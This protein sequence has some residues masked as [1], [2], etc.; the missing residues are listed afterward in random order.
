MKRTTTNCLSILILL[1]MQAGYL[2]AQE[3]RLPSAA[4]L[5]KKSELQKKYKSGWTNR[6]EPGAQHLMITGPE[7]NCNNAIPVCQQTYTQGSSYTGHGTIQELSTTC[8]TTDETNSV[9]YTFT[10]QNSGTFTFLLN[11]ANDYDFALYD[12]TTIGCAGVPSATPIRCNFSA[13]YGS[14]GLTLPAGSNTPNGIPASGVPTMPGLN[15]TAGQTFALIIDNYSANSNGY[16]LTFGGTAQIFDNT[17]P[18]ISSINASCTVGSITMMLNEPIRCNSIEALGS[19]F[20]ITGPGGI[21]IPVTAAVGNCSGGAG[22]T[23]QLTITYNNSAMPTGTYT[24]SSATGTDGNTVLDNCGNVMNTGLTQ[25]FNHL[26][27]LSISATNTAICAGG[28][29]V[30]TVNGGGPS[31]TY[32]WAPLAGSDSVLTVTPLVTTNYA[33]TVSFGGCTANATQ[34]IAIA[35]PPVVNVNPATVSLCSGVTSVLA[36][37][38]M[39][40]SICTNCDFTWTGTVSQTDLNTSTSTLSGVGAGSYSVQV[41]SSTGCV[42][43]TAVSTVSIASPSATP[44]CDIIYVSPAGGGDGLTKA[45]PTD[46]LSAIAMSQCNNSLLKLQI[47]DYTIN[48]PLIIGSLITIEGGYNVGFT[49][50]TSGKAT[51]GGFPLQGTRIIRSS[52]NPETTM[53]GE[54]HYTGIFVTSG[55]SYFRLQDIMVSMPDNAAGTA[56]SNYGIYLGSSCNNYNITRCYIYSGN[57]GSGASS[58]QPAIAASGQNGSTGALNGAGG[59]GALQGSTGGSGATAA[60]GNGTN[61]NVGSA[62]LVGNNRSG[63]GG[64]GGGRGGQ[65]GQVGGNGGNGGAGGGGAVGGSTAGIGGDYGEC[66]IAGG[67]NGTAG[68]NGATGANGAAAGTIGSAGTDA[69]G[70]WIP[71]GQGGPGDDGFG[72]GGGEGGGAGGGYSGCFTDTRGG[73]GGGGGGGG[74]GGQGGLGGFGGGSTYGIFIFNNGVNGNIV[75][76][77]I[78]NGLAGAGGAGG[79]GGQGGPGGTGGAGEAGGDYDGAAGGAGGAGGNGAAGGVGSDGLADDVKLVGGVALATNTS[80]VLTNQALITAE[81]IACTNTNID[82]TATSANPNWIN[83]G[84]NS[85]PTT[86]AGTPFNNVQYTNSGLQTISLNSD[87][88]NSVPGTVTGAAQTVSNTASSPAL[89][90]AGACPTP[91]NNNIVVSGYPAS[92]SM[93][94]AN[95]SVRVSLGN[96]TWSNDMSLFLIAPSGQILGLTNNRANGGGCTFTNINFSDAGGAV[97]GAT[98]PAAGSTFRPETT[99]YTD[100]GTTSTIT[101]FA[102]IGGAI[103]PNGTWTLRVVD[104]VDL[105]GGGALAISGWSISLP[106]YSYT[107][108]VTATGNQTDVYTDFLNIKTSAPAPGNILASATQICPDTALYTATAIG[109]PGFSFSWSVLPSAGVTIL[110][111]SVGATGI[112][113]PNATANPITYTVTLQVA[114]ECCGALAPLTQTITVNPIPLDPT[115]ANVATC[116]GG[117]GVFSVTAP[118]GASFDWYT[119]ATGGSSINTGTTYSVSPVNASQTFYVQSISAD[120]CPS[121]RVPVTISDTIIP[122]PTAIDVIECAPG[123]VQVGATAVSG[124]TIYNWYSDA[125]GTTLLQSGPS[126]AYGVDV[127]TQGGTVTVYVSDSIPGCNESALVPVVASVSNNPILADT[128]YSTND[129]VCAGTNVTITVVPT[130]GSGVYTYTWSPNG[131]T[132]SFIDIT[133]ATNSTGYSVIIDDGACAIQVATPLIVGSIGTPPSITGLNS[134]CEGDSIMLVT[135]EVSGATYSWNGPSGAGIGTNDTLVISGSSIANSGAYTVF[136]NDGSLCPNP[137]SAYN[138]TVNALPVVTVNNIAAICSGTTVSV[139]ANNADSY[140]WSIGATPTGVNT[141][142]V[143]PTTQTTYTVTGLVTATG[144]T[145]TTAFTV[146][147]NQPPLVAASPVSVCLGSSVTVTATGADS[148]VWSTTAIT[149]TITVT[150]ATSGITTYTV[151]GTDATTTCTNSVTVD[152]TAT[153]LPVIT[154]STTTPTICLGESATLT[155]ANGTTYSWLPSGGTNSTET[156]TPGLGT[157][158]YTVTGTISGCSNT[159]T[160]D[161]TVN[162]LPS[163]TVNNATICLGNVA[164]LTASDNTNTY[165][166]QTGITSTGVTTAEVSPTAP[167]TTYTVTGMSTATTC[168]ATVT[169]TVDVNPLPT[170]A[171]TNQLVCL[172]SPATLTATGTSDTYLWSNSATGSSISV[173]PTVV[174]VTTYTVTGTTTSTSCTNSV[175]VDVTATALPNVAISSSASTICSGTSATLTASGATSYL[176]STTAT[177]NSISVNPTNTTIYSVT[178]TDNGCSATNSITVNVNQ[179]PSIAAGATIVNASCNLSNGSITPTISGGTPNYTY[180]WVSLPGNT[181]VGSGTDLTGLG[182]GQYELTVTDA[183]NCSVVSS[184]YNVVNLG[185]VDAQ[186]TTDVN[187]G[188]TPLTVN[189]TNNSTGANTYTWS[190]GNGQS[191]TLQNPGSV[192]YT[193]SGTYTMTLHVTNNI[194]CKDSM[195]VVIATEIPS[196]ITIPNIFSPNGDGIN[197]Q[198]TILSEGLKTMEVDIFNR[199][200]TKVARV[201]GVGQS[202]DGKLNNGDDASEGTYFYILKASGL[203]GKAYEL[204]GA[205]MLVK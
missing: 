112:V 18:A 103:N 26:G 85:N 108:L 73:E 129:T 24:L 132:T 198:F 83:F 131:E 95:I 67:S 21:T 116:T 111:P 98:C 72:G 153:D 70:I 48:N 143:S 7:Q 201:E 192:I 14:T 6:Q 34:N 120:G 1:M 128:L 164:T 191:S 123:T 113:F 106:T 5:A 194:G 84:S 152:V 52:L 16:T 3:S 203:D 186:F 157:T 144:C 37:A 8:L 199:W 196:N 15:V 195:S 74:Q 149:N 172:G 148:Y 71:G 38:T 63:G 25:T 105:D 20:T 187:S 189:I 177:G 101:T 44:S 171:A 91:I 136:V 104:N 39:N 138:V 82:F 30:I 96:H 127:L 102:A 124:A 183:N 190:F 110:T 33:V 169:F 10:V 133:P 193:A 55:S 59:Q 99:T 29:S 75:D 107:G 158:Q 87:V 126:L 94:A 170:I 57:A 76:C 17:P 36:T 2:L 188:L 159:A 184:V 145:D 137:S 175:T 134:I 53:A 178:G 174:G 156:V 66:I 146:N 115:V 49:D 125:A 109:T 47:G 100:C 27:P 197:D 155:A 205:M 40:G 161:V 23:N 80:L 13:T 130:G 56:R 165:T 78:V 42:G 90:T 45:N 168:T 54:T 28:S 176:W 180:S 204:N 179:S 41:T 139:T 77:E 35:N 86:G 4:E 163:F 142:D 22:F 135:P 147:V 122:P 166:W 31:A 92:T 119:A 114:T 61:G 69:I 160:V 200:G 88:T 202:W 121:N 9:W 51:S 11:T 93:N 89:S 64:G 12:I 141:A 140:T 181:N 162:A 68:A 182:V 43:N 167:Q 60:V 97:M 118:S 185:A 117:A 173:T 79:P 81:N 65:G 150:P 46:L 154:A 32:S 151:T 19:D 62:P 58:T 50:K